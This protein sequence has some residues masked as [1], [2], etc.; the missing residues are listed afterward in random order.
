MKRIAIIGSGLSGLTLGQE[1]SKKA[2]VC[3]FEKGRGVGG[4][5]STRYADPFVFDHGA[6]YWTVN[7]KEFH[8]FLKPL[9]GSVVAE[10]KGPIITL[11]K[12][13]PSIKNIS[14]SSYFVAIPNMNSLCKHI[15][16]GLKI[17]TQCEVTSIKPTNEKKWHLI[18]RADEDLGVYDIV[19]STA[20]TPQTLKL[21]SDYPPKNHGIY[22]GKFDSCFALMIGINEPWDKG[23]IAAHVYNSPIKWIGVNSTKPERNNDVTC[24]VIHSDHQWTEANLHRNIEEVQDL[25]LNELG[26]LITLDITNLSYVSRHRWLYSKI[27][28]VE[29]LE[30]FMDN[31][32]GLYAV[33]DWCE[34]SDIETVWLNTQK[35]SNFIASKI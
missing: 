18:S 5:M 13:S 21:F 20:P 35:G 22:K 29:N 8:N 17:K 2:D 27:Q 7:T 1:L 12:W 16:I 24:L 3:I 6:P 10:W 4:R 33:G 23:W 11:E 32:L 19:I 34:R 15:A 28:P 26:T 30:Y 9:I 14:E 31:N 25:L